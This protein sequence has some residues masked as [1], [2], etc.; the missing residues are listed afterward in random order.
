M[1]ALAQAIAIA[2]QL[3]CSA[4]HCSWPHGS[5]LQLKHALLENT[6]DALDDGVVEA[7]IFFNYMASHMQGGMSLQVTMHFIVR[8]G[9]DDG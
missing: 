1:R 9:S 6:H 2:F 5:R 7:G 4:Q 3:S 8:H